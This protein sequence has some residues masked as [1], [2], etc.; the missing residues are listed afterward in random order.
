MRALAD[1]KRILQKIAQSLQRMA[2]CR[3]RKVE[4]LAGTSDVALAINGLEH[5]KQV[6]VNLT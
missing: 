3:L 2:D 6:Q 5:H 4:L 1:E